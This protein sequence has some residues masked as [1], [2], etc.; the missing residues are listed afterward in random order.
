MEI[1]VLLPGNE[2]VVIHIV[3]FGLLNCL[4][5]DIFAILKLGVTSFCKYSGIG[6]SFLYSFAFERGNVA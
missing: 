1:K 4:V 6:E 5:L 2:I 3:S